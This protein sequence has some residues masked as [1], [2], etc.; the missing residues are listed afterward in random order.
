VKTKID[1]KKLSKP[2]DVDELDVLFNQFEAEFHQCEDKLMEIRKNI[3]DFETQYK[4]DE[5]AQ[6]AIED[7]KNTDSNSS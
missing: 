2:K 7:N 3:N 5:I 4:Q 1:L 6:E